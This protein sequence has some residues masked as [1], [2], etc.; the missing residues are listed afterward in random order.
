VGGGA[1]DL[2]HGVLTFDDEVGDLGLEVGKGREGHL[3]RAHDGVG[4]LD[5][6]SRGRVVQRGI[7]GQQF[8]EGV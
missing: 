7:V 6:R 5:G 1:H 2:G 3:Q 4:P 8:A